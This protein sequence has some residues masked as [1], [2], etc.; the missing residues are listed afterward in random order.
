MKF[1]RAKIVK[2]TNV[3]AI[4]KTAAASFPEFNTV[5]HEAIAAPKFRSLDDFLALKTL[6]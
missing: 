2:L 1:G 4:V 5:G 3:D 6:L